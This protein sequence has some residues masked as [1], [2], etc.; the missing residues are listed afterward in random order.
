[1]KEH[2]SQHAIVINKFKKEASYILSLRSNNYN[3]PWQ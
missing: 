2:L 3:I 1:M